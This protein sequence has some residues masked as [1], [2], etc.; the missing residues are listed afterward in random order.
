MKN[1]S[2]LS[3]FAMLAIA[4]ICWGAMF[5]V[6][7]ATLA[8]L[9]A[10]YMTA[11]RYGITALIFLFILAIYE[12]RKS[13][14]LEGRLLSVVFFGSMGFAGFSLLAFV[15]LAHSKPEH[16]AIIMATMPLITAIVN[17][18]WKGR[19]PARFTLGAI[20]T[21]L[22]GVMLVVTNGHLSSL[23]TSGESKGD[24]LLLLGAVSWVIYTLGAGSFPG[25]SPLRYTTLTCLLGVMAIFTI[26][27]IATIDGAIHVPSIEAIASVEWEL[28]Y[29]IAFASVIAVLG[30]NAGIKTAGPLNGVLFINFVPVTAFFIG[31][32]QGHR[33]GSAELMGAMLVIGALI[34]NNLYA[35]RQLSYNVRSA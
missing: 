9:D 21:A 8:T 6:A 4:A 7:K 3:G 13:I 18:L 29:M 25:W 28:A 19:A 16:G 22:V 20:G 23:V 12:G 33:F 24:L 31:I 30:W 10:F 35:R 2:M 17:W 5:P 26:T 34:A 1:R 15:G 14:A 11:I 32:F 27:G